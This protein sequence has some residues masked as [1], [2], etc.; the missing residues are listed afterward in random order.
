MRY[1]HLLAILIVIGLAL[2]ACQALPSVENAAPGSVLFQDDFSTTSGGWK[3]SQDRSGV[4]EYA[5][6]GLRVVI[7]APTADYF[8]VPGLTLGDV[9]V[10]VDAAKTHG[11]DNNDFGL[12]CRYK[13]A[14]NFYFMKITSDGYYV[15]GKFKSGHMTLIGM[16]DYQPGAAIR[17]GGSV[18]HIR[19]D[20]VGNTLTLYAN[21]VKLAKVQDADFTSGDV[22]LIAGTFAAPGVAIL[23]DNFSILKP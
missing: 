18:N 3:L 11:S 21:G 9:R 19:A 15:I 13:D 10:E 4:T 17:K 12:I 1:S 7:N 22:G 2:P 6:G 14:D 23:F 20:C 5:G 8:T 16:N